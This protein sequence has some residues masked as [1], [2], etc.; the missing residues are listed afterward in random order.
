MRP[1]E[2]AP[3]FPGPGRALAGWKAFISEQFRFTEQLHRRQAGT[4]CV[5]TL[6][7]G[8]N[9]ASL[10]C[11]SPPRHQGRSLPGGCV[12]FLLPALFQIPCDS[13]S[14][15]V[16]G[17]LGFVTSL[18]PCPWAVPR[19]A[20]RYFAGRPSMG[21]A[22]VFRGLDRGS[23]AGRVASSDPGFEVAPGRLG[24]GWLGGAVAAS[25][26]LKVG[27]TGL[28]R[29]GQ[30]PVG[31][32][33]VGAAASGACGEQGREDPRF[34]PGRLGGWWAAGRAGGEGASAVLE[35]HSTRRLRATTP[36]SGW[37]GRGQK[38]GGWCRN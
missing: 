29:G 28:G 4:L 34:G 5:H 20:H 2:H 6:S 26:R 14:S 38:V 18:L 35:C 19:R 33:R 32:E 30:R 16:L 11:A 15:P 10:G 7:P 9:A 23:G 36:H 37:G 27:W 25:E 22:A 1:C 13:S 21:L 12:T 8:A 17:V 24:S 3:D 31:K